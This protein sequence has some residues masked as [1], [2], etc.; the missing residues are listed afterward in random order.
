M[1]LNQLPDVTVF[2]VLRILDDCAV[3]LA[4]AYED[5]AKPAYFFTAERVIQV[6]EILNYFE[7]KEHI[8]FQ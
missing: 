6:R 3:N 2:D 1:Q 7:N 5:T 4:E 8:T